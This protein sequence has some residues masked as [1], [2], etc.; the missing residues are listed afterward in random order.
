MKRFFLATLIVTTACGGTPPTPPVVRDSAGVTIVEN[1]GPSWGRSQAWTLSQVPLLEIGDSSRGEDYT[2]IRAMGALRFAD[3]TI[4]VANAGT[5]EVRWYDG[6]GSFLTSAG[7]TGRGGV[8]FSSLE[9]LGRFGEDAALAY[10]AMNLR[11]SIFAHDGTLL[12]SGSLIVMFQETPGDVRGVFADST[13]LVV[14]G[15]RHW[16]R[17]MQGQPNAPQ[18]LRR[19]PLIAFRY[20]Y[21][22]GSFLN[23]I[24]SY[25]GSEQIFRTGRTQIVHVTPRPFGRDAVLAVTGNDLYVGTEDEYEIRIV[26][27]LDSLTGLVRLARDNAPVTQEHIDRYKGA[28][29]TNVHPRERADR[30]AEL[31]SLPYPE[32]MPAYEALL[33][34]TEGNLWVEDC[35]P[36]GIEQPVWTVFDPSHRMLGTVETPLRLRI[37]DIGPDY[38]LGVWTEPSGTE[39]IRMYALEKPEAG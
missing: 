13:L 9:W 24:G 33:I 8:T 37:F 23:D 5:Q 25:P 30:E 1:F 26:N 39:S 14:R 34:D 16:V 21:R 35:R 36:F 4:V 31:D 28:R 11:T 17:A 12:S 38:V 2:I 3:G 6:T 19:G 10:D 20:A 22:D 29:L 15:A 7:R 32:T 18:G 27:N